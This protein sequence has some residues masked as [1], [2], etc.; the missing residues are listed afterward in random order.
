MTSPINVTLMEP[1]WSNTRIVRSY[2]EGKTLRTAAE[3]A[4]DSD[5][6]IECD[7]PIQEDSEI[8]NIKDR[9]DDAHGLS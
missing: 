7:I 6:S 2:S 4:T 8:L 9:K 5:A 3:R 1:Y